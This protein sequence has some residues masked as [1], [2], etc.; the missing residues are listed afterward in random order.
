MVLTEK[1]MTKWLIE[2]VRFYQKHLSIL[3]PF[4]VCRFEPTCSE[5]MI[6]A[7]QRFGLKG[8]LLGGA[9]IMR[10]HPFAKG[11]FDPVPLRFSFKH[12]VN[13]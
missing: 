1:V 2:M 8:V 4:R 13:K 6:Q 10:C 11:G 3:R 9:R 5:Y 12:G 7:I